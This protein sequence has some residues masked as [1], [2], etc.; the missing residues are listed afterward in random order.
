MSRYVFTPAYRDRHFGTGWG[1]DL[2]ALALIA[3][4]AAI[5]RLLHPRVRDPAAFGDG[6]C[7]LGVAAAP[8]PQACDV[9]LEEIGNVARL[10]AEAAELERLGGE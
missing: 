9:D 6:G 5:E 3:G 2:G 10:G 1:E 7:E 8:V 4:G